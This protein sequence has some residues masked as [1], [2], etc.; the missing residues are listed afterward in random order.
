MSYT[1]EYYYK[2]IVKA[3][4][5]LEKNY[6]NDIR[7]DRLVREANISKFYFIRSFK[8]IYNITPHKYLIGLRIRAAKRELETSEKT[9]SSICFEVGFTSLG[10]F[11]NLFTRST[12]QTPTEYRKAFLKRKESRNNAPLKNIPGCYGLIHHL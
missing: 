12:S 4:Q 9:I 6:M 3:K 5:L 8:E 1:K 10:S 7:L 11:S 2:K